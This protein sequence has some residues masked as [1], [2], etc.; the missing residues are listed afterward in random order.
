MDIAYESFADSEPFKFLVG[1]AAKPFY[2]HAKLATRLSSFMA[3]LVEGG[4]AEAKRR[5]AVF[6]D[7]DEDT[8]VRVI[9]FAYTGDYAAAEPGIVS[10]ELDTPV[11]D[12]SNHLDYAAP[13]PA[14]DEYLEVPSE[15]AVSPGADEPEE[16][17]EYPYSWVPQ[18]KRSK[19]N[20]SRSKG[21]QVWD[22]FKSEAYMK[23]TKPWQPEVNE[24]SCQDYTPVFLCYA[25]L[26][27]FSDKYGIEPLQ[28]LV[29]QKLRL[30]LSRFK[31][32]PQRVD[33]VVE[34][35]KYT[36]ANT[37]SCDAQIDKL[38]NLVSDYLV[39]HIEKIVNHLEFT[40][41]LGK[42]G[43]VAKDLLPKLVERRLD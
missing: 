24:D 25:K 14:V 8:F 20:K 1:P 22:S 4:M 42:E 32:H 2:L 36:Y 39:C 7:I 10:P 43:D 12:S 21:E 29:L 38:R 5:Y 34:L 19:K 9:Q 17:S 16:P 31:L 30:T 18:S 37:V 23:E 15:P 35:L 26:Y 13:A 6:E 33:D 11:E 3:A 27:V 28:E 41:L 40:N